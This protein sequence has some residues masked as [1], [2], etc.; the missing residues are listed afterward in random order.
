MVISKTLENDGQALR[1]IKQR[2][3]QAK[4]WFRLIDTAGS[5]KLIS[6]WYADLKVQ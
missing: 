3:S 5:D 6:V 2:F 1:S 4:T